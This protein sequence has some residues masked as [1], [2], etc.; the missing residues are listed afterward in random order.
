MIT[1]RKQRDEITEMQLNNEKQLLLDSI[2]SYERQ[3]IPDAT[4]RERLIDVCKKR[5]LDVYITLGFL[6]EA[7]LLATHPLDKKYVAAIIDA[8]LKD[9]TELCSCKNDVVVDKRGKSVSLPR[10]A[11]WKH[12]RSPRHNNQWIDVYRCTKC[13]FLNASVF[14]EDC[15]RLDNVREGLRLLTSSERVIKRIPDTEVLDV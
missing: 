3:Y 7:Q 4:E 2:N 11:K 14:N 5:L 15:K 9:D 13:G 1:N 12:I 6:A 10:F 8:V